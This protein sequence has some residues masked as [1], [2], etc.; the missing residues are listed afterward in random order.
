M[1]SRVKLHSAV[2]AGAAGVLALVVL[3]GSPVSSASAAPP[4]VSK[5]PYP[6][7]VVVVDEGSPAS[8]PLD[9]LSVP[10]AAVAD[11]IRDRLAAGDSEGAVADFEAV[12]RELPAP[13]ADAQ[14]VDAIVDGDPDRAAAT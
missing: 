7:E 11:A 10:L 4:V 5:A 12:L 13:D 6:G 2:I 3:L 14:L 1:N 8:I 9:A